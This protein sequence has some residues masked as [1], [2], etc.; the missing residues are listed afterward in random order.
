MAPGRQ[1][2]VYLLEC[3]DGS[4][5]T[6]IALDVAARFAAHC[7]GRGARYTRSHPPL[8]VLASIA[9]ADRAA[10]LREEC[11]IKRLSPAAKRAYAEGLRIA[12]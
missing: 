3:V 5:Y 11:R 12:E 10:A 8:R 1:W 9:C 4:I 2:F 6:G 7:A